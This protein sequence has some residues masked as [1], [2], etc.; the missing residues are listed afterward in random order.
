MLSAIRPLNTSA[1]TLSLP[2]PYL[3]LQ[4]YDMPTTTFEILSIS[5]QMLIMCLTSP[6]SSSVPDEDRNLI[7]RFIRQTSDLARGLRGF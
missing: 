6:F 7:I 5:E 3:Q 1:G 4:Y 2:F